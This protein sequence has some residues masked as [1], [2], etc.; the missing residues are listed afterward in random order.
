MVNYLHSQQLEKMWTN[1]GL[2]EGVMLKKAKDN[3][4][5]APK[6]LRTVEG[7]LF[8]MVRRLNVRCAMT[9]NTRIIKLFLRSQEIAYVPLDNGLRIQILPDVLYLPQCQKHHFAAFIQNSSILI[10]WDDDPNNIL[11]RAQ[12]IEDQ[13]MAMIWKEGQEEEEEDAK[14]IKGG[15]NS[16][17]PSIFIREQDGDSMEEFDEK[18]IEGPRKIV[19]IQTILTAVVI[20]IIITVFGGGWRKIAMELKAEEEHKN[21]M[22]LLFV[23]ALPLSIL[24]RLV[25]LSVKSLDLFRR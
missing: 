23:I 7:G 24:D 12:N 25:L 14:S 20:C 6:D 11:A 9:I 15:K 3:Y 22:R 2:E 17:A 4:M 19:L 16:R 8:E 13:L 18:M 21:W 5:C 1:G 10:V